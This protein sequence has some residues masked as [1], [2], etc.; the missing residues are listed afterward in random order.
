[1]LAPGVIVC[2][3][4]CR[5]WRLSTRPSES[6]HLQNMQVMTRHNAAAYCCRAPSGRLSECEENLRGTRNVDRSVRSS[7]NPHRA[8]C[9]LNAQSKLTLAGGKSASLQTFAAK[10]WQIVTDIAWM[11]TMLTWQISANGA[12]DRRRQLGGA[13]R[14]RSFLGALLVARF[15]IHC[16][17][18]PLLIG[19]FWRPVTQRRLQRSCLIALGCLGVGCCTLGMLR[20]GG[21]RLCRF[22]ARLVQDLRLLMARSSRVC[23]LYSATLSRMT[24]HWHHCTAAHTLHRDV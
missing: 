1:M 13:G 19:F 5:L 3:L 4:A 17:K 9:A 21:R 11:S 15:G 16:R 10:T 12:L 14:W 22:P 8:L 20:R 18:D 2:I 7:I 24:L 23:P 6:A